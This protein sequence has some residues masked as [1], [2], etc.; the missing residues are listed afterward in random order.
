MTN[1]K[2]LYGYQIQRG[3]LVI[4]PQ[5]AVTVRRVITLYMDGLSYQKIANTLNA[6]GI[7]FSEEAPLWNKHKVKRLLENPRYAGADGYPAIIDSSDFQ[8]I[9]RTIRSKTEGYVKAEQRPALQLKEYL[10]CTCGGQLLRTAGRNRRK[11]TLYLKCGTCGK[12]F[13]ILD[14]DLLSEVSK[15]TAEHDKP[16]K[17]GYLP[18]ADTLRLANA[19]NRG[20]ERPEQPEDVVKLILQGV[21]A[22]YDCCPAPMESDTFNRPAEVD[23][24]HFG[25]ATQAGLA[26]SH[27]T[28]SDGTAIVHFK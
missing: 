1:R 27:I 14:S 16:F 3:E 5:E 2:I 18:S 26:V 4:H 21:S 12:Q 6:D 9:Q 22:R 20:L 7:P 15:Q 10:R 8:S 23:F 13:K 19:I 25:Q 11:D 28:I 17:E 24:K